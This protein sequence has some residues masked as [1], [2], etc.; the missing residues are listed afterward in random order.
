M[1]C[2][3]ALALRDESFAGIRRDHRREI[4]PETTTAPQSP[5]W[6]AAKIEWL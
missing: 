6:R 1:A 5:N 4:D 3:A 2:L